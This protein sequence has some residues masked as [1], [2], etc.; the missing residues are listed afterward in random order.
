MLD[1]LLSQAHIIQIWKIYTLHVTIVRET[2]TDSDTDIE[3]KGW[4]LS[5]IHI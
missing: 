3:K 2:L 4:G 5:L 1:H